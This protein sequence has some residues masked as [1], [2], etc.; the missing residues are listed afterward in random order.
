MHA[1]LESSYFIIAFLI[2]LSSGIYTVIWGRT[3]RAQNKLYLCLLIDV[4]ISALAGVTAIFILP[5]CAMYA[6]ARHIKQLAHLTYFVFHSALSPLFFSYIIYATGSIY[7]YR[8]HRKIFAALMCPV[9]IVELMVLLN[10]FMHK[11]FSLDEDYLFIRGEW[12]TFV[13]I[14]SAFY[15]VLAIADMIRFWKIVSVRRR[16][17]LVFL[18]VITFAGIMA[19]LLD[20]NLLVELFAEALALMT[21]MLA[22]ENEDDRI[23]TAT[24]LY[25]RS[26]LADDTAKLIYMKQAF[27]V[28]VARVS[29][30]D[31]LKKLTGSSNSDTLLNNVA[32]YFRSIHPRYQIYKTSPTTFVLLQYGDDHDTARLLADQ[33]WQR[34]EENW[35]CEGVEIRLGASVMLA[36]CLDEVKQS[37]EIFLMVDTPDPQ[38]AYGSVR[39]GAELAYL[40]HSIE[41]EQALQRGFE[42]HSFEVFYQPTYYLDTMDIHS[43]E[44]LIRLHDKNLGDLA[45]EEFMPI[46]ER[47][48]MIDRIGKYVLEETCLFLSSGLPV[49]MG[50]EYISINLSVMQC[51]QTGFISY[52]KELISRYDIPASLINFEIKESA[53]VAD[54]HILESLI[55]ELRSYGF[56]FSMDSYG[57]GFS[58]MQS[59]FALD[60]DTIKIDRVVLYKAQENRIGRI[61]LENI[62]STIREMH[63]KSL[64]EGVETQAQLDLLKKLGVDYV[65]GYFSSKPITRNEL[66]GILR[67]TE[68][69]RMEERRATAASEAKSSFLANMSHE[70]RTP[71]NAV[72]GMNEMILREC[73]EDHVMGYAREIEAA[74]RNLL[75]LINNI[76]DYSKIEAGDM[77]IVEADYDLGA[78]LSDVVRGVYR[79]FTA[80]GLSFRIEVAEDV[81]QVFYGDEFRIKQILTNLL[82][83][84]IKFTTEGG[85]VLRVGAESAEGDEMLLSFSVEDTGCGIREEDLGRLFQRFER[86]NTDKNLTIAGGGLGLAISYH[87]LQMMNGEIT[88]RSEYGEGSEFTVQLLQSVVDPTPIGDFYSR[89]LKGI[90]KEGGHIRESFTA[91]TAYALIVDDTPMNHIVMRELLKSIE[92]QIDTAESGED[93]LE[94][95]AMRHYDILFI[96]EKMPGM[97]GRETLHALRE[98]E[99]PNRH[100]PAISLTADDYAGIREEMKAE[101]FEDFLTKPVDSELLEDMLYRYLP[102]GK[103]FV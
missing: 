83:N 44:A 77:E 28:I 15:F 82:N 103:V 48:G 34:F 43:A 52:L 101:G 97:S 57:T 73:K 21:M 99:G 64:V 22:V 91:P 20:Q 32:E 65:Q 39:E 67:F 6:W 49:E 14:S 42:E 31:A 68:L 95:A 30:A 86:L 17:A 90:E 16:T 71:I 51:L 78:A 84:A 45:P 85:A 35:N 5:Y 46:A 102:E 74:G 55:V 27:Y 50:I 23:D 87:L 40:H 13:Y 8:R 33:I 11:V 47:N 3:D 96:D 26:A 10:P 92:I 24:D 98:A 61:I 18:F 100:T 79:K 62:V 58:D 80:K 76:L 93:C 70:I 9:L 89:Y 1:F 29:N 19:Q 53:A 41:V 4:G 7:M 72:L 25:N 56:C 63:R 12:E 69:A 94:K 66:L 60:L 59:V 37:E 36:H 54:Y 88:A 81:P 2:C 75:S 38:N